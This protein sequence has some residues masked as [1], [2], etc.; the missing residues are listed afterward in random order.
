MLFHEF[1]LYRYTPGGGNLIE[2]YANMAVGLETSIRANL[3]WGNTMVGALHVGIK[4]T[5]NP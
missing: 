5:H 4:L 3:G 1:S 2:A